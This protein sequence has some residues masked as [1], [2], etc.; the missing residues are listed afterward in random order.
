MGAG[1]NCGASST[2]RSRYVAASSQSRAWFIAAV[3]QA[4]ELHDVGKVA[5]PDAILDKTGPLTENEWTFIRRH[6]LIGERIIG[7][8]PALGR[9]AT[10][11]RS[12]HENIDGSGYPDGLSGPDI[13]LGSRIISVCDAFHA[14]TTERPYRPAVSQ[15]EALDELS[16]CAGRQFD[17]MVVAAFTRLLAGRLGVSLPA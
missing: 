16:R 17:P 15:E 13:P 1:K 9:I 10:L 6:T 2:R 14:M 7:A 4:A 3:R 8:A 5:I 11:V 12:T